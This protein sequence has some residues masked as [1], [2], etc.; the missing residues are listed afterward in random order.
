MV[1]CLAG[2]GRGGAGRM[3]SGA[4][5]GHDNRDRISSYRQAA[6]A[7]NPARSPHGKTGGP[8]SHAHTKLY[9]PVVKHFLEAQ[10]QTEIRPH[11]HFFLT[12]LFSFPKAFGKADLD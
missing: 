10:T 1:S 4:G 2:A 3:T 6:A 9:N 5:A 7:G 11:Y 12:Q 8:R